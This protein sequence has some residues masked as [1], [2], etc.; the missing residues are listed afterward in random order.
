MNTHQKFYLT[1]NEGTREDIKI[2]ETIKGDHKL[3]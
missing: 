1:F 3:K 2:R